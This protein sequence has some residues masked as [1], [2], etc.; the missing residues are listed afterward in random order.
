M[1]NNPGTG[2]TTY[3]TATGSYITSFSLFPSVIVYIFINRL[4]FLD[5]NLC[6]QAASVIEYNIRL[7]SQLSR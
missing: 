6:Q 1:I 4:D 5:W 2:L 7:Q 3:T